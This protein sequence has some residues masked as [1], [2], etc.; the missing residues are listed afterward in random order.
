MKW[1]RISDNTVLEIIDH[2]PSGKYHNSIQWV[3]C[4]D[5]VKINWTYTNSTFSSPSTD[6]YIEL[7]RNLL[8]IDKEV[9]EADKQ[10]FS[11]N[12]NL[13][14]PDTEFIQGMF[15]V[16]PL[17]PSNYTESWKTAEKGTDGLKN[18]K[19][20][21]NKA[22]I[23]GLALAYLQFKKNNWQAGEIKKEALKNVFLE[24]E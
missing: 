6:R 21:L 10:P 22:G 11:F 12:G 20:V 18:K 8:A 4:G 14:Y 16:L 5:D 3:Q 2:N 9:E 17:L 7:E 23:T 19:V 1:A 15:S 24:G 13:Y